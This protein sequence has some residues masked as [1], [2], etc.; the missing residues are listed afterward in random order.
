MTDSTKES[1]KRL[2]VPPVLV[3]PSSAPPRNI[4]FEKAVSDMRAMDRYEYNLQEGKNDFLS[5]RFNSPSV[6]RDYL[7]SIFPGDSRKRAVNSGYSQDIDIRYKGFHGAFCSHYE[8]TGYDVEMGVISADLSIE[9]NPSLE[10]H[11]PYMKGKK[12]ALD[13]RAYEEFVSHYI[14]NFVSI[15]STLSK[16]RTGDSLGF[17][18][19][20]GSGA[21]FVLEQ[22]ELMPSIYVVREPGSFP[23]SM[24]ADFCSQTIDAF[25]IYELSYFRKYDPDGFMRIQTYCRSNNILLVTISQKIYDYDE[26]FFPSLGVYHKPVHES[27]IFFRCQ[28]G[29]DDQVFLKI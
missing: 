23:S 15:I 25:L 27:V 6:Y 7:N 9:N 22:I 8:K 14:A 21:R 3:K 11:L 2:I 10:S 26:T 20:S 24:V 19:P 18:L 1:G 16:N 13:Y 28:F 4:A 12:K 29:H 5:G 17:A